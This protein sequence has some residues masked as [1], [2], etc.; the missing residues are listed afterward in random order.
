MQLGARRRAVFRG[1]AGLDPDRAESARQR[2]LAWDQQWAERQR[3]V[4]AE[5]GRLE[6]HK[7]RLAR[8]AAPTSS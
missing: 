3:A 5:R 7:R 6:R 2:H 1:R 8:L 4:V